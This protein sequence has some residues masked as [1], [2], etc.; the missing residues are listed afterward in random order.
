MDP[1]PAGGPARS[2]SKSPSLTKS[3]RRAVGRM[4]DVITDVKQFRRE[5][6]RR[7]IARTCCEPPVVTSSVVRSPAPSWCTRTLNER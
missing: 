7:V 6:C 1:V 5:A 3:P 2:V 4:A